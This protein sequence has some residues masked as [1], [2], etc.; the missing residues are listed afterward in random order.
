MSWGRNDS[1]NAIRNVQKALF[2]NKE[3]KRFIKDT[4]NLVLNSLN[5]D[6]NDAK[7]LVPLAAIVAG[8]VDSSAFGPIRLKVQEG[9]FTPKVMYKFQGPAEIQTGLFY[10]KDF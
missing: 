1:R 10:Q 2:K 4:Q 7:Y 9:Y 5:L 8:K 3:V 6:V